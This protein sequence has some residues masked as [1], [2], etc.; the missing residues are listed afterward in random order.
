MLLTFLLVGCSVNINIGLNSKRYE[1][2]KELKA[3]YYEGIKLDVLTSTGDVTVENWDEDMVFIE[4]I[5]TGIASTEEAAES[6]AYNTEIEIDSDDKRIKIRSKVP[7]NMDRSSGATVAYNIK[8]PKDFGGTFKSSTGKI[9]IASATND[10][11]ISTSTGDVIISDLKGDLDIKTSTGDVYLGSVNGN[12]KQRASTGDLTI[13]YLNGTVDVA[14]STGKF[15]GKLELTGK[16]NKIQSSTGDIKVSLINPALRLRADTSTGRIDIGELD[17]K[18]VTLKDRKI[19]GVLN[20]EDG[21][22]KITTSTGDIAI[23]VK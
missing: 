12:L 11:S 10:L 14:A 18:S 15:N 22:L 19:E 8:I 2:T 17:L 6:N 9:D 5:I 4:A 21:T 20:S 3:A 1:T 7:K 13:E 16:N 23:N